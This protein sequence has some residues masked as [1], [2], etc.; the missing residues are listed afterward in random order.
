MLNIFD[1]VINDDFDYI[2]SSLG[3]ELFID[4]KLVKAWVK[5]TKVNNGYHERVLITEHQFSR[6]SII[7]YEGLRYLI[8]SDTIER[9]YGK[10]F[11]G[12][13]RLTN[14]LIYFK[15]DNKNYFFPSAIETE[16]MSLK[17]F[18][19]G[20]LTLADGSMVVNLQENELTNKIKIG[21]KFYAM[22][23]G[24][25]VVGID[26]S[27]EGLVKLYS[28]KATISDSI[29]N[30]PADTEEYPSRPLDPS[31]PRGSITIKYIDEEGN[32]LDT[33]V[34]SDLELKE[35][36]INAKEVEGYTLSDTSSKTLTL[37]K[38][39][40]NQEVIFLYEELEEPIINYTIIVGGANEVE[41]NKTSQYQ[42]IVKAD[43][44]VVTDKE[45]VWEVKRVNGTSPLSTITQTGLLKAGNSKED[46]KVI[47]RLLD[48]ENIYAEK[49]VEIFDNDDWGWG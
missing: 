39:N 8:L 18:N 44:E 14:E 30:P 26:R 4:N 47:A 3:K 48:N 43:N 37:T 16:G 17:T 46:I 23:T 49:E 41:I 31:I 33:Q 12:N 9:K 40:P 2:M 7:D 6:G 13:M 34:M 24:W 22:K 25:E 32:I 29:Q 38:I 28:N 5:N 15:I 1:N 45:V 42:A 36:I 19:G 11:K 35:Y 10:Y 27:F 20:V 21:D